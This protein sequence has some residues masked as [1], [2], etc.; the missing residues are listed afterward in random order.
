[1][2]SS[3]SILP[4]EICLNL[5][6]ICCP[7]RDNSCCLPIRTFLHGKYHK[8]NALHLSYNC[9]WS[10]VLCVNRMPLNNRFFRFSNRLLPQFAI[11]YLIVVLQSVIVNNT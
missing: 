3:A 9:L 7:R 5:V 4:I 1:M 10:G 6:L 8:Q 11:D 2:L